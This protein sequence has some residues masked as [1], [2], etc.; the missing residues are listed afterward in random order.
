MDEQLRSIGIAE[1][2]GL[3]G[4]GTLS[5]SEFAAETLRHIDTTDERL[6]AFVTIAHEQALAQA[7]DA[8]AL[9]RGIGPKVWDRYPLLGVPLSV[10]DLTPVKDMRTTRGSLSRADWIPDF[11]APAVARLRDAGAIIVGK[12]NTSEFGWSATTTNRVAGTTRNPWCP[13][14]TPGGSSG[15]A[16][17]AVATGMGVAATGTDGAGSIRIPASFCGIVGFKPSFG[18][19]PY[20]PVSVENLSHLGPLTRNVDDAAL[21]YRIL[22]GPDP[23]DP[24][25]LPS[26]SD[27]PATGSLRIGWL[28]GLGLPAVDPGILE[29]TRN[30]VR[31][32]AAD[33]HIVEEIGVGFEDPYGC[34]VTI[35]ASAEAA[36]HNAEHERL[37]DRLDQDRLAVVEYGLGLTA[38]NLMD[39]Y[40]AKDRLWQQVR[41]WLDRFDIL[42]MPTVPVRPF[43]A[44]RYQPESTVDKGAPSWLAWAP[45]AYT[46]NLTGQPA[47]SVPAGSTA[48]GVPVGIQFVGGW[49]ADQVVLHAGRELERVRP[50]RHFY[51]RL[52]GTI[53]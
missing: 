49:R 12:T 24:L 14:L 30:A 21:L 34:L 9:I 15:G 50:W 32:L 39:A 28:P 18:R 20:A 26:E 44:E 6:N 10:K 42:A 52:A 19:V 40:Q 16:A 17:A 4:E 22:T 13:E 25:S 38:K 47:L 31:E 2:R 37:R 8:E 46:F 43:A 1:L 51:G 5:P 11:D 33:G 41:G 27:E 3:Y 36:G 23:A 35:L 45:T 7:A 29:V 53:S 48:D